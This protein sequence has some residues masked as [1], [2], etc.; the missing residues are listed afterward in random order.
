MVVKCGNKTGWSR[1]VNGLIVIACWL[2]STAWCF[3]QAERY[4]LGRRLRLLELAFER[5]NDPQARAR[6]YPHINAAVNSFFAFK[7]G[8]VGRNIDLAQRALANKGTVSSAQQWADSVFVILERRLYPAERCTL[9]LTVKPFY[10]VEATIPNNARLSVAL[11]WPDGTRRPLPEVWEIKDLPLKATAEVSEL[12]EGD[13]ELEYKIS[14]DDQA[15]AL[16][17]GKLGIAFVK[18]LEN[19]L[20]ALSAAVDELPAAAASVDE[21]TLRTNVL[22]LKSLAGVSSPETDYPAARL[23]KEAEAILAVRRR[24]EAFYGQGK[25]GQFWLTLLTGR[26][27]T[28]VRLLAPPAA[29]KREPLPLVIALHGAGGSENMFFDVY[30]HGKIVDLCQDRGWLLVAPRSGGFGGAPLAEV[31]DEVAK[32]YPVDSRRIF[33]VG[34]SMGAAQ[35][36]LNARLTPERFTAIAALGGGRP[37]AVNEAMKAPAYFVGIGTNDFAFR[38]A[39]ALGDALKAAQ[40]PHLT[41]KEYPEVEHLMIV[42][43]SLNDV[44]RFFEEAAARRQPG[45]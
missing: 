26:T 23:L 12:S 45:S 43:I 21:A 8:E 42:Q 38:G 30:G 2:S 5:Q 39:K 37:I 34:H 28:I 16:A 13:A 44:F 36:L 4:E 11:V 10:G 9:A 14:V 40:V 19:R 15:T 3:A 6:A 27:R 24:G 22:L 1:L 18:N 35:A 41:Y 20:G 31:I 17:T 29:A 33:V 25:T 7:F 32:L